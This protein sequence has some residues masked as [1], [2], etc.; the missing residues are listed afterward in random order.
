MSPV[1]HQSYSCQQ[2]TLEGQAIS[3]R[4]APL[5]GAQGKP[6]IDG[7]PATA[8]A[9]VIFRAGSNFRASGRREPGGAIPERFSFLWN[10]DGKGVQRTNEGSSPSRC[11]HPNGY[12]G[13]KRSA[14]YCWPVSKDLNET[15]PP[16][17]LSSPP[18]LGSFRCL[19]ESSA[20]APEPPLPLVLH[21]CRWN[22]G[23]FGPLQT[24]PTK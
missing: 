19:E 13:R 11:L 23:A 2:L 18:A 20:S 9:V 15:K 8:A 3:T 24:S 17:G 12:L 16:N 10:H 21:F 4:A 1:A 5:L 14:L 7:G 6:R 22:Q